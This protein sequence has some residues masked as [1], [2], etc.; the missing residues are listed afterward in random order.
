MKYPTSI[1]RAANKNVQ[2]VINLMLPKMK[3]FLFEGDLST[4]ISRK[5]WR[6]V[7]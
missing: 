4:Y 5:F 2:N 7:M 1:N 6:W 3:A